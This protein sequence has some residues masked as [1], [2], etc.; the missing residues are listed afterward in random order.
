MRLYLSSFRLGDH[1]EHLVRLMDRGARVAVV[2]NSVDGAPREVRQEAVEL[3]LAALRRLGLE[4]HEVDLRELAGPADV[5]EA[6]REVAGVWV[7]G[8]N[9]FVL[10]VAMR[11]SGADTAVADAVR[12]DALVYAGYSAGG[13]VL[14]P[15][16]RG[17]E[18]VDPVDEVARVRPGADVVWEGLG[19]LDRPFV[20]HWDSPGHPETGMIDDVVARYE[21]EGTTHWRLRDGQALVVDGDGATLV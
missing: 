3:E 6:L 14:A 17:L 13:C 10:R 1:P 5:Q 15:D 7:R 19:L 18:L 12:A 9:T 20:P 16:L 8:G 21:A 11:R 2:A 4:P